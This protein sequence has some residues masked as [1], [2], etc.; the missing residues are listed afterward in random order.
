MLQPLDK[1]I[2]VKPIIPPKKESII[3]VKDESPQSFQVVAIGDDVKK[4]NIG[5]KI[6]IASFST[7]EVTYEGEKYII[8]NE[9]N[10][11]AKI[12]G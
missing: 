6:L 2:I 11:I 4:V 1:R 3:I 10:I 7:S 8:V 12:Q 9:S 5:D